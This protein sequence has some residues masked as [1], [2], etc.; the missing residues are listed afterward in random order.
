MNERNNE[1]DIA[2]EVLKGL[3]EVREHRA[4][5]LSLRTI[6]LPEPLPG[7]SPEQIREVREEFNVSRAVFARLLRVPVR[8]LEGW[9]QGRSKP[10][11]AA[12]AL[13]LMTRKYPD[14]LDRLASL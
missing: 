7:L 8:T 5:K 12:A 9:E 11:H 10:P 3:R 1:R 14:T 13:I 6:R 2:A 4:G